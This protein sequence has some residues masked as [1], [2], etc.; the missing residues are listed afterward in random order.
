MGT[1][2][3][4]RAAHPDKIEAT[5][6]E[7]TSFRIVHINLLRTNCGSTDS[8][9]FAARLYSNERAI[10]KERTHQSFETSVESN[11]LMSPRYAAGGKV[12]LSRQKTAKRNRTALKG[13]IVGR[14]KRR[15][16]LQQNRAA[17]I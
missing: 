14:R 1:G 10:P 17:R 3:Y 2:W 7:R 4:R 8:P 5:K 15:H 9:A 13:K 16:S 12:D 6:R 11:V